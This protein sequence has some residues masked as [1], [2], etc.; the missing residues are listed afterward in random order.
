MKKKG[1]SISMV[2]VMI[3]LFTMFFAVVM[4]A[5]VP[6]VKERLGF[7]KGLMIPEG[8][9]PV[10]YYQLT[11]NDGLEPTVFSKNTLSKTAEI[12]EL[13]EDYEECYPEENPAI[14]IPTLIDLL[15][16]SFVG[17]DKF[18]QQ[19][20]VLKI[21]NVMA[22]RST[23]RDVRNAISPIINILNSNYTGNYGH[24]RLECLA[25][26]H[27]I[28]DKLPSG[29]QVLLMPALTQLRKTLY[30]Y[31]WSVV[32][33][34]QVEHAEAILSNMGELAMPELMA[35]FWTSDRQIRDRCIS[36]FK[37]IGE[38]AVPFLV[39]ALKGPETSLKKNARI[40]LI[41]MRDSAAPYIIE[42]LADKE[43]S[44]E[45]K[46]ELTDVLGGMSGAGYDAI[47]D[48]LLS[49]DAAKEAAVIEHLKTTKVPV[50]EVV[51]RAV[52]DLKDKDKRA[53]AKQVLEKIIIIDTVDIN[54]LIKSL[55]VDKRIA[56][57]ENKE[58]LQEAESLFVSAGS[59]DVIPYKLVNALDWADYVTRVNIA[60]IL[61]EIGK[62][63]VPHLL[64]ELSYGDITS[65]EPTVRQ[66]GT[67]SI[68][69]TILEMKEL[70]IDDLVKLIP[71]E[72]KDE[73]INSIY[74][75][76]KITETL[77]EE[78]IALLSSAVPGLVDALESE[79]EDTRS[80]A[81]TVLYQL[82][83]YDNAEVNAQID[84][85]KVEIAFKKEDNELTK[86]FLE[87]VIEKIKPQP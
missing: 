25:A 10:S 78:K 34:R 51:E 16:K 83:D 66:V 27:K 85:E 48:A 63:A 18:Y 20:N 72:N 24:L 82:V 36:I 26:L 68:I 38:D 50:T 62:P 39:D 29:D 43:T 59:Y 57:K 40:A 33:Y 35:V 61:V 53:R 74:L 37:E 81:A 77:P 15:N 60:E 30:Y 87:D 64:F 70:A 45:L 54:P 12:L 80:R 5:I 75:I 56:S 28:S 79:D 76:G 4:I 13:Y 1:A 67:S 55:D 58:Y 49:G 46:S 44:E 14:V 69:Y 23:A 21:F 31:G 3:I 19:Q 52:E 2:L 8:C 71:S 41:A 11:I 73:R 17:E 7:A 6:G 9:R 86:M 22:E 42:L 65:F 84:L 47:A 32:T